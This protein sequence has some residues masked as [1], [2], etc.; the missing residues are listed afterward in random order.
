MLYVK[1]Y[2]NKVSS[3]GKMCALTYWSAFKYGFDNLAV[4]QNLNC[5]WKFKWGSIISG[6]LHQGPGLEFSYSHLRVM[7]LFHA[8][9]YT[10]ITLR[11]IIAANV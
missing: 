5:V 1:F 6:R 9:Y 2:F 4:S 3:G 11:N 10:T 7:A 8:V